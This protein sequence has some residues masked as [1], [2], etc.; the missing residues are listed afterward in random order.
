V[1]LGMKNEKVKEKKENLKILIWSKGMECGFKLSESM[2]ES[3]RDILASKPTE[4]AKWIG[5]LRLNRT[6]VVIVMV[7]HWKEEEGEEEKWLVCN[8]EEFKGSSGCQL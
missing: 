2:D 1:I 4:P 6:G 5:S 8:F 3:F 7:L